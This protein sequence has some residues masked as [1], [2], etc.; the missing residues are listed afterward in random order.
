MVIPQ[1]DIALKHG[2]NLPGTWYALGILD[3]LP[4][5]LETSHSK[6]DTVK[7]LQSFYRTFA[8][9]VHK[10]VGRP[11]DAYGI[12]PI[13]LFRAIATGKDLSLRSE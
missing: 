12:T 1:A 10:L 11:I 6:S 2:V 5:H 9:L 8:E 4:S 7:D 3:A 13:I